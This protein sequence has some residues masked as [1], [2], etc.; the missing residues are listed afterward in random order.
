MR[1]GE[2]LA[3]MQ[4]NAHWHLFCHGPWMVNPSEP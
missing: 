1:T 4:P 2:Y 3:V